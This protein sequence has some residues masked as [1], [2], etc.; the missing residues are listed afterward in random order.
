MRTA[1]LASFIRS[2]ED[3]SGFDGV[4]SA[5]VGANLFCVGLYQRGRLLQI[6]SSFRKSFFGGMQRFPRYCSGSCPV[7]LSG[8]GA[9][10]SCRQ[11]AIF[12]KSSVGVAVGASG[13]DETS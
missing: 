12:E 13:A 2:L 11:P 3:F 5:T 6:C 10:D 9:G 7:A 1:A 4:I 8:F